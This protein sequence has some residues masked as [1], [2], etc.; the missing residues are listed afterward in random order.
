MPNRFFT[1]QGF[2][3]IF[4]DVFAP[5]YL[6]TDEEGDEVLIPPLESPK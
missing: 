5:S 4:G 2:S 1:F 6:T 3:D